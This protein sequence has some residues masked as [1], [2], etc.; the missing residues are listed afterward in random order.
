M[1]DWRDNQLHHP[2]LNHLNVGE[3]WWRF[4]DCGLFNFDT[5][6]LRGTQS[7]KTRC[8]RCVDVGSIP[9]DVL[10][11]QKRSSIPASAAFFDIRSE[12]AQRFRADAKRSPMRG[13]NPRRAGEEPVTLV[14]PTR[15]SGYYRLS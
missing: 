3:S 1:L 8:S 11:D 9:P 14:I 4:S 13:S 2:N 12:L 6:W 7:G 10:V 5:I 15:L